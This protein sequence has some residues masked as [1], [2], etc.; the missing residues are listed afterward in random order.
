M[1]EGR[2]L[3]CG[4][5]CWREEFAPF[6]AAFFDRCSPFIRIQRKR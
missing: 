3:S 1:E 5:D 4:A 6:I 2:S